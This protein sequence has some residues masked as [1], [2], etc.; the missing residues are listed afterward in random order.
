VGSGTAFSDSDDRVAAVIDSLDEPALLLDDGDSVI[1]LNQEA[2]EALAVDRD[3]IIGKTLADDTE[4]RGV[5]RARVLAGLERVKAF[6]ADEQQIDLNVRGRDCI[7]LLKR[8]LLRTSDNRSLGILV[9]LHEASKFHEKSRAQDTTIVAAAQELNTPLTSLALAVGLLQREREKQNEL[10]REITEDVD[11]LNHASADFL[12]VMREQPV[13]ITLPSVAFDLRTVFVVIS[14]KFEDRIERKQIAFAIHAEENLQVTGDPLKLSWVIVTLVGNAL[15]H[16][17][18][19]GRVDLIAEREDRLIR[20]TVRDSGPGIP[21]ATR[22]LVFGSSLRA[23]DALRCLKS[24][25]SLSIA[26]QIAEAHGGRL[27]AERLPDGGS[28]T[29]TLP[30][31]QQ[32]V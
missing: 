20:I 29:L 10:I 9:V 1:H 2:A 5:S 13:P 7:Y 12:N 4:D 14:R 11:R 25:F 8:A 18:K 27:F 16:T 15:R 32:E 19:T 3:Q 21:P 22:D 23:A 28:V 30:L 6:P 24:G 26:R 17:P 31:S